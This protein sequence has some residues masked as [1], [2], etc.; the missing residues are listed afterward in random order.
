MSDV[1]NSSSK[2][3][4]KKIY[5]SLTFILILFSHF[6]VHS[7][8]SDFIYGRLIDSDSG[9]EIPFAT[10]MVKDLGK[11][12]IS[13]AQG[14]FSIPKAIQ[15]QNDTLIISCIGYTSKYVNLK[16][17]KKHELNTIALKVAIISLDE[18]VI[19]AKKVKSLSPYKI[20]KRSIEQIPKNY[21]Q[22]PFSHVAYYRDYQTKSDNYINLNEALIEVFDD[23]FNTC[24]RMDTKIRL[25]EY[26]VNHEFERDSTLEINYDN[27]DRKFIPNARIDP[28]GGNELTMLMIH[29]AIRNYEQPAYSF[30]Y[31]MKEDFLKNHKFKLAKIIKMED[32]SFY[33]IDFKLSNP[34]YNDNYQAFGQ[35]FINRD[36]YAIHKLFYSL[37][38]TQKKEKQLIFNAQVE[39]A[40]HQ[41]L[42]YLNYI[43]FSN[44]FEMPNPK[45]FAITEILYDSKKNLLFVTF[46]NPYSPDVVSKLSNYKVKVDNKKVDVKE[47]VKDSLNNKKISLMLDDVSD[48]PKITD[49][50]SNRL[51]IDIKNLTDIEG[52]ILGERTYLNYK[53]YREMFVQQVQTSWKKKP[54]SIIDKFLPLKDNNISEST[55]TQ[56]YW[57]NTPLMK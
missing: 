22:S 15:N 51:K 31:I 24:D 1:K 35:L 16:N 50:D 5:S 30:M 4:W 44:V 42:M 12:V 56:D 38:N 17:L 47:V 6:T 32:G 7:Q 52:R 3:N 21:S 55:E 57:M 41:D 43:S 53:Q 10:I 20:V 25:L 36:T 27:F 49:G 11:G 37:Y 39:Y 40:K 28:S 54:M 8:S 26:K 45:D 18:V 33:V 14:D 9:E 23:G 19:K 13:N 34:L 48:F 46:N 29:D 2:N